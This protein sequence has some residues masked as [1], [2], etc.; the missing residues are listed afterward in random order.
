MKLGDLVEIEVTSDDFAFQVTRQNQELH[1]DCLPLHFWK[2]AIVNLEVDRRIVP[3]P[4]QH[5][6]AATTTG[7]THLVTAVGDP[8]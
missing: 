4:V 6:Q 3:Q 7:A 2:F 5:I 1:I 8:L